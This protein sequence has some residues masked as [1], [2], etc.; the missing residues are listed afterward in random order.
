MMER[1]VIPEEAFDYLVAQRGALDD[2]KCDI[3]KWCNK[4]MD[5]IRSEMHSIEPFLPQDCAS[6]LDIGSGMGGIDAYIN[7]HYGGGCHVTLLDGIDD[8][9]EVTLHRKTF[10]HMGIARKFLAFNGVASMD[11]IDAN[12]DAPKVARLYDLIVSFKSWCFHVEPAR[13]LDL[14]ASACHAETVLLVDV[15]KDKPEWRAQLVTRFRVLDT[16]FDGFK[17]ATLRLRPR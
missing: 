7:A 6:I 12:A 16:V 13:Y 10:N 11:W 3:A 5:V 9:P 15:R 1:L 14:V 2:M 8:P 17:F 4:Y